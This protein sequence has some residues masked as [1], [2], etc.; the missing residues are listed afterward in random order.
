MV[1]PGRGDR[2]AQQRLMGVDRLDH[3]GAEEQELQVLRRRV[4]GLQQVHA[5]VGAHRPVVVLARPVDARERLL[6]QQAD[7]PVAPGD[8]L[9]DLHGQLLVVATDVRVLEDRR[10]LV[11]VGRDLVVARLDGH[12][13]LGELELGLHHVREDSLRDRAEVVVVQLVPLRRLGAEQRAPGREQVGAFEVVLLVDQEVLLLRSHGREYA[14]G[15]VGRAEQLQSA[16]RRPRQRVH[17]A[18]QRD[19]VVQ[20]LARPGRERRRD[21]QQRSVGV[22]EDERRRGRI[23]GG[24]PA[25][26]E[27]RADAAGR[28]R[29]GVG[30]ALDQLLAGEL[31]DRGA[32]ARRGVEGVVLLRRRAGQ[33]LKPVRVVG[34]APLHR[35]VLHRLRDRVGERGV[36]RLAVLERA[37]QRAVDVLGQPVALQVRAEHVRGEHLVGRQR[38]VGGA[39]RRAVGAPLGGGDVVLAGPGGHGRGDSSCDVFAGVDGPDPRG[40]CQPGRAWRWAGVQS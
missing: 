2:R 21:A 29:G 34:G 1:L 28:E 5:G 7:Q 19:L 30:L 10:E 31:G 25:R 26:L 27:R 3:G 23:P 12:A 6:V 15:A 24:V 9:H 40:R 16:D 37:L 8:V 4:P 32:V 22:L 20:R 13:E 39:E 18:Q 17:R 33:R 38:Q 36:Q 14:V 35:P 11:L